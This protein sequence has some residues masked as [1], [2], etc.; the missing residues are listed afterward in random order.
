MRK[1]LPI[2][3]IFLFLNSIFFT[4]FKPVYA[5]TPNPGIDGKW[6][7]D[8]EVTFVGKTGAR[9]GEFLDWVLQNYSWLC[10]KKNTQ[11]QCDN[12]NNPLIPFW[13]IIRNIVYA[14]VA[15]F[16]LLTAFILIITRGQSITVMRFIP[17]FVFVIVLITLSFSLV[18]FIYQIGDII[19]DFF[20][21]SNGQ[22][23]TTK[24]LLYIGFDYESFSGYRKIGP[25]FEESAFISL[26]LVRL[27]AITYYVMTGV[28]LVRKIILWFF[29]IISPVFPLLLFYRPIRNTAKIWLGEFFRWLL[30]APLFAI[31]LHG[32]VIVWRAGIPL[33]FDFSGVAAGK[34][35]YPTAINILLGGPGQTLGIN[36]SVN[37]KDT[38]A[39]YVVALLMLWVV[40]LLPFL[41]LKIFLDYINT[42][43]FENNIALRQFMN[44]NFSFLNPSRGIPPPPPPPSPSLVQPTGA[45]RTLPFMARHGTAALPSEINAHIQASVRESAEVLKL[46]NLSVPKLRDVAR[47]EASLLSR[48]TL[49]KNEVNQFHSTLEKIGNPANVTVPLEREKF[50][51]VRQ[52]LVEQKQKG[53]PLASSILTASQISSVS[54]AQKT[55]Q[56]R[57]QQLTHIRETLNS[58]VNPATSLEQKEKVIKLKEQL[59]IEKEKG[60]ALATS[61]LEASDKISKETIGE[62]KTKIENE[63]LD[64]LLHEE[65]NG[66]TLASQLVQ[67]KEIVQTSQS[68]PVINKVQQVSLDD[69]E[70]VR[71]LWTENYQT[72]EPPR[73]LSG[74]QMERREWIKNDIEKINQA[75]NL[76][77]SPDPDRVNQGMEMVANILPFLLIGGFSKSEVIAYLKAKMEAGKSV[78]SEAQRK[79]EEEETM[80]SGKKEKVEAP[81]EMSAQVETENVENDQD[82]KDN[83]NMKNEEEEKS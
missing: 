57:Q 5:Q 37:L 62:K 78:L 34:V 80:I 71:K 14:L 16:V 72:I 32:L 33:P 67:P 38:F 13:M 41:L 25:Q 39:L 49:R 42:I 22:Y 63:V 51:S 69:Y 73:N 26:L 44:R 48:E 6:V 64:L 58:I 47:Y 9:S 66:N 68:L 76:L 59:T 20:L 74:D 82:S 17:R 18:Q 7:G 15:L 31:F 83:N 40:I 1:F 2:F 8:S 60:N 23:I 53:N 43:S 11:N 75:I 10:V 56:I 4:S 24:D 55:V 52:K 61:I 12:T 50:S 81:R 65:K 46:A 27:T 19:Q 35:I 70:E 30:Y 54:H 29:V 45:G 3:L 28:L 36:N 21:R 79:E 77:T